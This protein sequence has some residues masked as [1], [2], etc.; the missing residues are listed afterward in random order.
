[1]VN[2]TAFSLIHRN[3]LCVKENNVYTS[4]DYGASDD[5]VDTYIMLLFCK[6]GEIDNLKLNT[7]KSEVKDII[8]VR[9]L[10]CLLI[11]P[12]DSYSYLRIYFPFDLSLFEP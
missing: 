8:L 11:N 5:F 7:L 1:M 2:F 3:R 12:E 4:R 10:L 9:V 6:N